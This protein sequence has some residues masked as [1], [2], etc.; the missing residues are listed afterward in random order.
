MQYHAT[1]LA[2]AAPGNA[3]RVRRILFDSLRAYCGQRGLRD[4][5]PVTLLE[6]D[7]TEVLLRHHDGTMIRCPAEY[8]R[9]VEVAPEADARRG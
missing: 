3:V 9:F 8:A 4:G 1:S 5:G 7:P 2:S 6:A